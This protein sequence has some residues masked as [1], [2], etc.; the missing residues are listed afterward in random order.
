[1]K[2][3]KKAQEEMVGFALIIII[4][5][6]ILL[7]FL[8]FTLLKPQKENIES[9]EVESFL[10]S[11]MQYTTDCS[12]NLERLDIQG[13]ITKCNRNQKCLDERESCDVLNETIS[14]ILKETWKIENS[15]VLGYEL[16]ISSEK[17]ILFIS[18]GNKTSNYKGAINMLPNEIKIFFRAYY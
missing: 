14:N 7:I 10:D 16:N 1:M 2:M 18:K 11:M 3:I 9:Y 12:D 5:A 17:E 6:V 13:L 8:G 4:V 15:P